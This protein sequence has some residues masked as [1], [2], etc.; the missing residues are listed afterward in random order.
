MQILAARFTGSVPITVSPLVISSGFRCVT[1]RSTASFFCFAHAIA[2]GCL[3]TNQIVP[4]VL[5][6]FSPE[7]GKTFFTRGLGGIIKLLLAAQSIGFRWAEW[8]ARSDSGILAREVDSSARRLYPVQ[9]FWRLFASI[10]PWQQHCQPIR[11][12]CTQAELHIC[13][14]PD[15]RAANGVGQ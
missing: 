15:V 6:R 4:M 13:T 11:I 10:Y 8:R 12:H 14:S 1:Q 3:D 7:T 2:P 9:L 5:I